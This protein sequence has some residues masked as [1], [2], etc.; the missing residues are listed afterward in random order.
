VSAVPT[1]PPVPAPPPSAGTPAVQLA[2]IEMTFNPGRPNAVQALAAIDLS[3]RRG[4][5][6]SLI[7]PSGCGKSTLLRL[8][9][10]LL[11]PTTGSVMDQPT[12]RRLNASSTTVRYT[13][14]SPLGCSV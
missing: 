5:F 8:I 3:I 14:P 2:G 11:R 13:L 9:A 10:D 12:T 6:V 1:P 4:E 7:G